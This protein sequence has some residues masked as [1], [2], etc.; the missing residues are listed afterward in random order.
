MIRVIGIDPGSVIT[1]YGIVDSDGQR[2]L[3]VA[4]GH[5]R[6]EGDDLASRL[7][8]VF[9]RVGAVLQEWQPQEMAI[10]DVFVSRNALSALKLGQARGAAVVAA[11]QHRIPVAE[12][13]P[14]RVKQAVVGNGGADKTQIQHMVGILL[15]TQERLQADAAD[16]LAIALCH[17]HTRGRDPGL[18]RVLQRRR[19]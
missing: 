7:G 12:Y 2:S 15:N 6:V 16:A 14:R 8:C 10:E 5:I 4:H 1:G 13:T 11:C 9:Q 18:A 3:L 19:R 17:V